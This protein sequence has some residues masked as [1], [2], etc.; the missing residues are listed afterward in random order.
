MKYIVMLGDGM[1]DHPVEKLDGK[2]PLQVA[3]KPN[4]D[5][6][7]QN[8]LC[9]IVKT[10]PQ[11]MKPGSD[12]ANLSVMG[13]DPKVCYTGRSPLEAYSMG[14]KL[15]DSDVTYRMNLVNLRVEGEYEDATMVDYSSDEITTAESKV[16]VEYL[17][18]ELTKREDIHIFPGISYRH[19]FLMNDAKTGA[20]LTPPHDI[21]GRKIKDYL[22]K[23]E[24]NKLFLELMKKSYELLKDHPINAERAKKGLRSANSIWLWGEGTKPKLENF[25][26]K[27]GVKGAVISAVDLVKGIGLLA[28]MKVIEV[29]GATGNVNTNFSGKADAAINALKEDC[30]YV[31]IHVEAPDECGH[32]NE[33]ENKIRSIELIDE[34]MIGPMMKKMEEMDEEYAIMVLPDHPTP[35]DI[36]THT[37]EPVPFAI[38]S[39]AKSF[40]NNAKAY[41]EKS[42]EET[43]YFVQEG[44][45]LIDIL[46]EK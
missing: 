2:T 4:M 44:H 10:V 41:D 23:G 37:G 15:A 35:L 24:N 3:K 27:N 40:S 34:L 46:L 20:E 12:T 30:D 42:A 19:C 21:T 16:L 11:G 14:V 45:K 25:E 38:Y 6:I 17:A 32:R 18:E 9:G 31:Y 39:N 36:N 7:A 1:A 43:G 8:G 28:E 29:E 5:F 22:P 26:E 33:L 13:Y